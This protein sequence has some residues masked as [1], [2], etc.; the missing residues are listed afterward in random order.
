M[1]NFHQRV[2]IPSKKNKDPVKQ[3]IIYQKQC[4]V[5]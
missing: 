4:R 2:L 5:L 3:K 1:L